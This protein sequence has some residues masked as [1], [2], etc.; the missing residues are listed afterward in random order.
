M[1]VRA[2]VADAERILAL[3]KL[4]YISEAEIYNDYNIHPLK[5]T[6]A[7]IKRDFSSQVFLKAELDGNIV[8]SV[9]AYEKDGNCYVGRLIVHPDYQ[10]KGLGTK[11]LNE[12][13]TL[14]PA[15]HRFELFTGQKSEKNIY[16]YKKIGYRIFK[17]ESVG[18][19]LSFVF[20]EKSR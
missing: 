17:S 5:Q 11:L 8:G 19:N 2:T 15:C 9:K 14:F 20:L 10:N 1:I 12:I 16:L 3:Q 7:E 4:A 18:E 13:E 6:L